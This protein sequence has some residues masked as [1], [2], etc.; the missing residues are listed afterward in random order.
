MP[1]ALQETNEGLTSATRLN[2]SFFIADLN[3]TGRD[4]EGSPFRRGK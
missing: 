3:H 2:D 1:G 4:D